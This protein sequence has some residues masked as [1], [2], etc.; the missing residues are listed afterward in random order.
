ME[1]LGDKRQDD[2]NGDQDD[3]DP[4]QDFHSPTDH[5]IGNLLVDTFE[6]FEFS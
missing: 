6:S 1:S 2:R 3:D 5:L 4:F